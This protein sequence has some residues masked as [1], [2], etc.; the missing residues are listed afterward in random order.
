MRYVLGEGKPGIRRQFVPGAKGI[1]ADVEQIGFGTMRKTALL[2]SAWAYSH[3]WQR[4]PVTL[5]KLGKRFWSPS[6]PMR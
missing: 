2:S 3:D 6:L 1:K 5:S 4:L